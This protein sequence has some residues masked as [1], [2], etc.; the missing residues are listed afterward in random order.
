MR[1]LS[2]NNFSKPN[3]ETIKTAILGLQHTFT[4]FGS[5][6]L[7]PKLLG[8][9]ISVAIFM[10]GLET[11]IFHILTKKKVPIFLGS[12]FEFIP[13]LMAASAIYGMEYALG[14]VVICG[15]IYLVAAVLICFLGAEKIINMFPPV[16][17]GSISIAVGLVLSSYAI[18]M[19][20]SNWFIAILAF[21]I[22][23]FINVYCKGFIKLLPIVIGL[24][25]SYIVAT[26]ITV[27]GIAPLVDF[28]LIREAA[29]F[30][31]PKFTLAKF[32]LGATILI[33]PY[34]ICAIV[35]HFGDIAVAGVVCNKN[36]LKE[37]GIHRTLLGDGIATSI[38]AMFG[39][40]PNATYSENIGVLAV[41]R[42]FNPKTLR[43]AAV[44]AL[45][46]GFIPKLSAFITTI[47]DGIIGGISIILFG[48][49]SS[50]GINQFVENKVDFKLPRNFIIVAVI[51]V[52]SIG[53][54]SIAFSIKTVK[55]VIEG[56][57]LAAIVGILLNV[58]LPGAKNHS[59]E[60]REEEKGEIHEI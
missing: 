14:G 33:L 39:G 51:L 32:N 4:M 31:I 10:A 16:I 11:L 46:L 45:F 50:M 15:V 6:V 21:S 57:G 59:F 48:T 27:T 7:I 54:A 58:I 8:L 37:P 56:I 19:A 60:N 49:I 30:G 52:L 20:S 9:N 44:F 24:A 23:A 43:I 5:V 17:T 53:G 2:K 47:P 3:V 34:T 41:T 12:S 35:D 26:I 25:I 22:V 38:S 28:S 13:P 1:C 40:P 18:E 36:F 29:W 42:N 55:F